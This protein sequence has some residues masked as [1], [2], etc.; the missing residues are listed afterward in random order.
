MH[1]NN[2]KNLKL[3]FTSLIFFLQAS[4]CMKFNENFLFFFFYRFHLKYIKL[5]VLRQ[6]DSPF[7][8]TMYP[9]TNYIE[10]SLPLIKLLWQSTG[11]I[12]GPFPNYMIIN[13]WNLMQFSSPKLIIGLLM[14]TKKESS[15]LIFVMGFC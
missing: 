4:L 14:S 5:S 15:F 3:F 2:S 13:L 11:C 7:F 9:L 8:C 6:N 12:E 1:S 10:I